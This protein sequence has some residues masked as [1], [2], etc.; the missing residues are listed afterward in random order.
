V[1]EDVVDD[2]LEDVDLMAL[3]GEGSAGNGIRVDDLKVDLLPKVRA[4]K[5]A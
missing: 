1:A 3:M 4:F 2:G 5:R